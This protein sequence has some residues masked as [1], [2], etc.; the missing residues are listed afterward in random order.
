MHTCM[1]MHMY[2]YVYIYVYMWVETNLPY[3]FASTFVQHTHAYHLTN[4]HA[5]HNMGTTV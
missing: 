3:Q 5:C 2:I 4:M 1:H